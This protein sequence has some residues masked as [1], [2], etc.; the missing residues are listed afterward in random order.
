MMYTTLM[1]SGCRN[2]AGRVDSIGLLTWTIMR[3]KG[4]ALA[5]KLPKH[6]SDQTGVSY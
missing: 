4:D 3:M 2:L 1:G 6:K 5:I